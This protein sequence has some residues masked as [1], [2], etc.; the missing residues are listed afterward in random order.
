MPSMT[1]MMSTI[2]FDESVIEPI[3]SITC[4]TTE[5]PRWAT[6]EARAASWL[7][8]RALSAFCWTVAVS[9]RIEPVVCPSA[10]AC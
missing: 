5:P 10:A 6:S 2:F 7:A 9:S 8:W 1:P 3:V 4:D